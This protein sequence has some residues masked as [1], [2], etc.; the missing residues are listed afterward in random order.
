MNV[1][2]SIPILGQKKEDKPENILEGVTAQKI[3][4]GTAEFPVGMKDGN[5]IVGKV[6]ELH[7][8]VQFRHM[9]RVP[10]PLADKKEGAE[11]M[12]MLMYRGLQPLWESNKK[13]LEHLQMNLQKAAEMAVKTEYG[14]RQAEAAKAKDGGG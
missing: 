4:V 12:D 6:T 3:K 7:L 5:P 1:P 14:A 8:A 10:L 13:A 9:I 11:L 2:P